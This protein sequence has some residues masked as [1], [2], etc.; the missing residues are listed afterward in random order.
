MMIS[1]RAFGATALA[2]WAAMPLFPG[3]ALGDAGTEAPARIQAFYDILLEC[4]KRG[5]VLGFEGRYELVK[6]VLNETFDV[7]T[8]CRIAVGPDWTTMSGE[9]KG[10]LLQTFD[11]YIITT[12]AARF[13]SFNNQRFEVGEA[14]P[15]SDDRVLVETRLVRSNGEPVALNYLFRMTEN[16]WRVIDIYLAGS[17]S[18]MAQ[19][20]SEFAQSL[21][22][23]GSAALI[24]SLEEKIEE[25][26][27]EA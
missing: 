21:R 7:A 6:P 12:Y 14:K 4:M 9:E 15:A 18:Q 23:G 25:L 13:R 27:K 10:A 3:H 11:R 17:I 2:A 8:M 22:Q 26:K 20:R 19:L 1:R 24:S 5:D 16:N